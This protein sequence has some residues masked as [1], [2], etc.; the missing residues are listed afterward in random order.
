MRKLSRAAA[1]GGQWKRSSRARSTANGSLRAYPKT[2]FRNHLPNLGDSARAE[3]RGG[4]RVTLVV[5]AL[6]VV[7]DA[8]FLGCLALQRNPNFVDLCE[9]GTCRRPHG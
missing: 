1:R 6:G 8:M 7:L 9:T 4:G 3:K 2:A 5:L